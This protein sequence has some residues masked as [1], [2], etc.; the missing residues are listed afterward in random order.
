MW[1]YEVIQSSFFFNV[2]TEK[3]FPTIIVVDKNYR[4]RS[5]RGCPYK[6]EGFRLSKQGLIFIQ[7]K[8]YKTMDPSAICLSLPIIWIPF[9]HTKAFLI[10]NDR[11]SRFLDLFAAVTDVR[12]SSRFF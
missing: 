4:R 8:K 6:F 12:R 5:Y 2:L 7:R 3:N 11:S 10:I 9:E 1:L